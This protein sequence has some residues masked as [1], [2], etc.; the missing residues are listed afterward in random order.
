MGHPARRHRFLLIV[1]TV[2]ILVL[3][4]TLGLWSRAFAAS[5]LLAT[6][7]FI[8]V[9][10]DFGF[11][12]VSGAKFEFALPTKRM[13]AFSWPPDSGSTPSTP[14]RPSRSR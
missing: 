10:R 3:L 8:S 1:K 6:E 7:G 12:D 11:A 2:L 9:D 14:P 13:W 5:L 4:A